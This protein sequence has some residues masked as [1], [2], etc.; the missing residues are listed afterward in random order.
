LFSANRA[1]NGGAIFANTTAVISST[2]FTSN[3][4]QCVVV[5]PSSVGARGMR[6]GG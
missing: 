5:S 3:V 1:A 4:A 2:N 6:D